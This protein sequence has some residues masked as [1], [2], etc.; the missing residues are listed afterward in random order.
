MRHTRPGTLRHRT[1]RP[2]RPRRPLVRLAD[3]RLEVLDEAQA[4]RFLNLLVATSNNTDHRIGVKTMLRAMMMS[5][6]FILFQSRNT[7]SSTPL[8]DE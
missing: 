8:D 4:Q 2:R 3:S 1:R 7:S 5:P 6:E